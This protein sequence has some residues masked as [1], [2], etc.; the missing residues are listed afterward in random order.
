MPGDALDARAVEHLHRD[1][2]RRDLRHL[3]GLR[4]LGVNVRSRSKIGCAPRVLHGRHVLAAKN[5]R[6]VGTV[7]ICNAAGIDA[8]ERVHEQQEVVEAHAPVAHEVRHRLLEQRF[9]VNGLRAP[10][11]IASCARLR[12]KYCWRRMRPKSER[13]SVLYTVDAVWYW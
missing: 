6:S 5:C 4:R 3:G 12:M 11:L 9:A 10:L 1:L 2:A 8:A 7:I 13:P